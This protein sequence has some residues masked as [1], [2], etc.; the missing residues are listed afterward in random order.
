MVDEMGA[1]QR[2]TKKSEL[3][4]MERLPS[5]LVA[6]HARSP[7]NDPIDFWNQSIQPSRGA[8]T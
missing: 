2:T 4:S 3:P 6:D 8:R 7:E 5:S 1:V